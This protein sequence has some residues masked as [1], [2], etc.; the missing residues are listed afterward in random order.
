VEAE[1][2]KNSITG[3]ITGK[4]NLE[5]TEMLITELFLISSRADVMLATLYPF[6]INN[7]EKLNYKHS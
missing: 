7:R 3:S 4:I 2:V 1:I 5:K 6:L